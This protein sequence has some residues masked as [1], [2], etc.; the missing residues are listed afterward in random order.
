MPENALFLKDYAK[1]YMLYI[2]NPLGTQ[3]GKSVIY[4]VLFLVL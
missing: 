3:G 2:L 4:L 1:D